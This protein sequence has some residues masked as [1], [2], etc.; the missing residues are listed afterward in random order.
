MNAETSFFLTAGF[1]AIMLALQLTY[2]WWTSQRSPDFGFWALGA[3]LFAFTDFLFVYSALWYSPDARFVSRLMVTVAY[4]V[5]FLGAQRA[6]G[7]RPQVLIIAAVV[8]A[9][10][11]ALVVFGPSHPSSVARVILSRVI[12]G[13]FCLASFFYLR[14]TRNH[15]ADSL[16]SPAGIFL[17]QAI[18]LFLRVAGYGILGLGPTSREPA[19]LTYVDYADAVVFDVAL[20]VAVLIAVLKNRSD[21][22]AASRVELTTLS[23]LLPICAWCRKVRDDEGYW[24]EVTEYLVRH[25]EGKI[26]HGICQSCADR[27]H[28]KVEEGS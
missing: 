7:R 18:Y 17:V 11:L 25:N 23:G 10:G 2:L 19:L 26:T 21:E 12:W 24:H 14:Q 22:L 5:L 1:T 27:L 15:L 20:F 13:A 6:A 28:I 4:G 16:I 3:W 9:Y 8:V